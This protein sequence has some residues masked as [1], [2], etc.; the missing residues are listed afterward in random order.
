MRIFFLMYD[1]LP[2]F[3]VDVSILF[4]R[5]LPKLDICSDIVGQVDDGRH[6]QMEWGA[7]RICI[8]GSVRKGLAG[9]MLR[10][11]QDLLGMLRHL[12]KDHQIIQVRD[13]IRTGVLAWLVARMT[14]RKVVYWMSFPFVDGFATRA[15]EVGRSKGWLVCLANWSRARL[16]RLVFYRFLARRVDHLFVQSDEM[17]RM[18][19]R[20]AG[21]PAARMTAVPMGVDVAWLGRDRQALGGERPVPLRGRRVLAYVGTLARS[22]QPEFLVRVIEQVRVA[23]PTALLL[24]IGDA[25]SVDEQAWLRKMIAASPA[26]DAI[27]ITGWLAP[28]AAQQW[29]AHADLGFSPIPRGPLLD[30]GSPTKAI[31]YLAQGLPCVG[32]DNPD[33]KLVLESSGAGLCVP[34]DVDAFVQASL[35]ILR[36]DALAKRLSRSGPPWV[37]KHRSYQVLARQV[38]ASYR[39]CLGQ[40]PDLI[41]TNMV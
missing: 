10:P 26:A 28:D 33:Q 9:E 30:V 5:E 35:C 37:A 3:R 32:N 1:E 4:G 31:E 34:M 12:H 18:V 22:R 25:P 7:G 15:A 19:H 40:A 14:G 17:L 24:L 41:G 13:K 20:V 38:A 27:H 21:V 36:D 8:A 29:L 23:E 16:A 39:R 2:P 6:S 11:F